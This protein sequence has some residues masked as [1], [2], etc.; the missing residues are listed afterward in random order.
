M[1]TDWKTGRIGDFYRHTRK[2]REVKYAEHKRIP[3]VPMEAVPL[4]GNNQVSWIEKSPD[5]LTSGTYFERGDVLIAK[6]TPCLE[7]GK[8]ALVADL[9]DELGFGSTEFHVLR[10][11]PDIDVRSLKDDTSFL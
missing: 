5:E 1:S 3:F 11:G 8:A 6:I 2:P 10:P 4:G 9:P 7:N